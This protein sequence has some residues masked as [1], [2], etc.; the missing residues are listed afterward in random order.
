[1]KK[2]KYIFIALFA[3][4]MASCDIDDLANPNGSSIE[5]FQDAPKSALQTLVAGSEDLLRQDF[6]FY[7]DALQ[8][9]SFNFKN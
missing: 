8:T 6:G 1:M 9:N 2:F 4:S 7:Y 5:G 3:I